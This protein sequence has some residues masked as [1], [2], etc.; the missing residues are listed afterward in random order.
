MKIQ[1]LAVAVILGF[2]LGINVASA[3]SVLGNGYFTFDENG[4]AFFQTTPT[5][6][7][8]PVPYEVIADPTGRSSVP[9]LVYEMPFL[10]PTPSELVVTEPESGYGDVVTFINVNNNGRPEGLLIF[11]S[12]DGFYHPQRLDMYGNAGT[13]WADITAPDF[14]NVVANPYVPNPLFPVQY[15]DEYITYNANI[16]AATGGVA[17]FIYTDKSQYTYLFISD[18]PEPSTFGLLALGALGLLWRKRS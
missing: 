6:P 15:L 16:P 13:A 4:N 8:T 12:L 5:G 17:W 18:V 2:V 7:Q 9:V 1:K 10:N 3:Q 14:N 11:Y